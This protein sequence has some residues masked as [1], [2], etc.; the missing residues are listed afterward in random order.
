MPLVFSII[1]NVI[2]VALLI[3][4]IAMW[5]RFVF[6]WMQVLNPGWRPRGAV[7]VLAE[8]SYTITDPPI[9]AVRRVIPPLQLG[10]IR[11]DLAW[12]IVLIV[13]LI[14]MSLVSGR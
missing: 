3:V 13:L 14:L 10:S 1:L 8:S 7:V 5:A 2:Y 9:K 11:L 4:F 12:T 6:D